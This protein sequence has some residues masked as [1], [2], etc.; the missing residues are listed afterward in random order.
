MATDITTEPQAESA[1]DFAKRFASLA[2]R[3]KEE[4]RLSSRAKDMAAHP[5]YREII[6]MGERAVPLI[7]AELEK[8]ADHWFMAL[9]E[10]TGASPVPKEDRGIMKKMAAAWIVW[11][12][13]QGYRWE[14][15]M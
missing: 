10:I 1:E 7:L 2:A 3:W 13:E 4:T 11:G 5:A 14:R 8:E 12:H 15:G 6:A 9:R